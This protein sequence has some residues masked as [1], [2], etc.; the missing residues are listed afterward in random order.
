MS[1]DI[2]RS[3][4]DEHGLRPPHAETGSTLLVESKTFGRWGCHVVLENGVVKTAEYN[5]MD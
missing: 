1:V 2:L 4:A 3:F 5:F